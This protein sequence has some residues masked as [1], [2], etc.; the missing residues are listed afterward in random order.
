MQIYKSIIIYSSSFKRILRCRNF[1]LFCFLLCFL[2][3]N[4]SRWSFHNDLNILNLKWYFL[5]IIATI[6]QIPIK[7]CCIQI[8][9]KDRLIFDT[10]NYYKSILHE[11][12]SFSD[13]L[14]IA[15]FSSNIVISFI[16]NKC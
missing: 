6:A 9:N 3:I 2:F 4:F 7:V 13:Y 15:N 8:P 1:S 10:K 5:V 11:L 14:I 16:V 12:E